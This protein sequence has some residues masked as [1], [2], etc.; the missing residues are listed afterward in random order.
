MSDLISRQDAIDMFQNLAYDDW[1]QGVGTTLANAYS[2]AAEMI[3]DL[4][5]A[6]PTLY[7]YNIEHLEMIARVLQKED[8]PPERVVEA[9]KDIGRI[10]AIAKDEFEE[11]LRK[12][13]EQCTI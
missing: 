6:Q 5:S 1:N 12:A 2:E 4:P 10:V 13:V 9:L 3:R 8:L 7:G 11:T